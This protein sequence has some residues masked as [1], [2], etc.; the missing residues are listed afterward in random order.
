MRPVVQVDLRLQS[1]AISAVVPSS[2]RLAPAHGFEV[3]AGV[4]VHIPRAVQQLKEVLP[5]IIGER[6]EV[7]DI[8]R[9]DGKS[10]CRLGSLTLWLDK[11]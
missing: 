9:W 11:L 4:G 3:V 7:V 5:Q 10:Q 2:F 8:H 6:T 1:P